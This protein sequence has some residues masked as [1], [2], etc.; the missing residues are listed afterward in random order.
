[1]NIVIIEDELRTARSLA[2][3]LK[4]MDPDIQILNIL[5]SVASAIAF[6]ESDPPAD[7]IFMDIQ[8]SDGHCFDIFEEVDISHPIIFCTAYNDYMTKAFK[9]SSIDYIL[10]PFNSASVSHALEKWHKLK[11]H[12]SIIE[13]EAPA[14]VPPGKIITG[15]KTSL[16]V[17]DNH[18][19]RMIS[20]SEVAYFFLVGGL[21]ALKTYSGQTIFTEQ[22][23]TGLTALLPA[24]D[25]YRIN[26]QYILHRDAIQEVIPSYLRSLEIRL[27]VPVQTRLTVNK[28]KKT[29]FLNWLRQQ[30]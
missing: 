15:H 23:L 30:R 7:L 29:E 27:K 13:N 25:F 28:N 22:S 8:L 5:S 10:K 26:R 17:L 14:R 3:L 6:F 11:N 18:S 24:A 9:V 19:Y 21:P 12:F 2:A 16:L 1:M 20:Y 4:E